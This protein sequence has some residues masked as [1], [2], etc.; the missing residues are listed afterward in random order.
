MYAIRSYYARISVYP[1][2]TVL[3]IGDELSFSAWGGAPPYT[4]QTTSPQVATFGIDGLLKALKKG[5]FDVVSTDANGFSGTSDGEFKVAAF[6]IRMRD[7]SVLPETV[8]DIP[9]YFDNLDGTLVYSGSV[10]IR[11]NFV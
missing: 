2:E 8:A 11:N 3:A 10:D 1:L 5:R 7:T 9:V 4:W 6:K